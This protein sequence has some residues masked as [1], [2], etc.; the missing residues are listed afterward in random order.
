M[1]AVR[2]ASLA[3]VGYEGSA[4]RHAAVGRTRIPADR[5]PQRRLRAGADHALRKQSRAGVWVRHRIHV[6]CIRDRQP[7]PVEFIQ[8]PQVGGVVCADDV[9]VEEPSKAGPHVKRLFV[10]L[11]RGRRY[12]SARTI[13]RRQCGSQKAA[14]AQRQ[15]CASWDYQQVS[16]GPYAVTGDG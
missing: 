8:P 12:E 2:I 16:V 13:A 6:R 1:R 15:N 5:V 9:D 10:S 11:P 4:H 3:R 14:I 7:H